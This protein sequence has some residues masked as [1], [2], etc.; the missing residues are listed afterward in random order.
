M[1]KR[2]KWVLRPDRHLEAAAAAAE[3]DS[4]ALTPLWK[5]ARQRARSHDYGASRRCFGRS[6]AGRRRWAQRSKSLV[7]VLGDWSVA[8]AG[9]RLRRPACM[10]GWRRW[11]LLRSEKS[12]LKVKTGPSN[13]SPSSPKLFSARCEYSKACM[14]APSTL[15]RVTGMLLPST[16]MTKPWK[17]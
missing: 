15:S 2:R 4:A 17:G 14:V 6:S 7:V 16:G 12:A 1:T 10:A 11:Q 8:L 13:E 3:L 9:C 5:A